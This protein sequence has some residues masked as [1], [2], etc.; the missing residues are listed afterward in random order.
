[1]FPP[2]GTD[3]VVIGTIMLVPLWFVFTPLVSYGVIG[4]ILAMMWL[5]VGG[6]SLLTGLGIA[7]SWMTNPRFKAWHNIERK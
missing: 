6:T 3:L 2:A 1:M 5:L 7:L 4:F